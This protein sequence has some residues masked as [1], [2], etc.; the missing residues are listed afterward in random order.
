M[1]D[2]FLTELNK[3]N[4]GEYFKENLRANIGAKIKMSS[5]SVSC[6]WASQLQIC[7]IVAYD[8]IEREVLP[9]TTAYQ[10]SPVTKGFFKGYLL[11]TKPKLRYETL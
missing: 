6:F 5:I 9:F 1:R 11:Q 2:S 8:C 4:D 10:C 7:S 3:V